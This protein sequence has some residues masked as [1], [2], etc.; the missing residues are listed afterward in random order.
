VGQLS[1]EWREEK[2]TEQF[3]QWELRGRGW[4]VWEYS[5]TP[6]PAYRPFRGHWVPSM[7]ALDDGRTQTLVSSLLDKLSRKI[8][9]PS[10]REDVPFVEE[11]PSPQCLRR[12]S[13]V[14]LQ[15]TLS[16]KLDVTR[17]SFEQL[18]SNLSFC[19]EPIAFELVGTAESIVVQFVAHPQDMQQVRQQLE[20]YFPDVVFT[21]SGDVLL[22][23]WNRATNSSPLIVEFGLVHE[24]MIPLSSRRMDLFV[25]LTAAL[26]SLSE[27]E[28]AVYQVL[29]QPVENPWSQSILRAVTDGFGKSFFENRPDLLTEAKKKI[30]RPLYAAVLRVA[31]KGADD[32]RSFNVARDLVSALCGSVHPDGNDLIPLSNE[33]YPRGVHE[34]DLL[35]RQSQRS[36]M[37]LNSSELI[38]LVH[39]P[40]AAVRSAKLQREQ[41]NSRSPPKIASSSGGLLLGQNTSAG[42][43]I[44]VRL[45]P[46]QR[47]RHVHVIGAS[48]TG[49]S[50]L[51]LSLIAQD[52][53]AGEG[54]AV[55][56]P[57]GD[58]IDSILNMIPANRV[59]DVILFDPSDEE[60]SIG[61][62]I[63]SAHSDLEK[64]LLASDL[65]SV[66]QRLST[67]WGDQ[68]SSVLQN[69]I[70][71]FLESSRGGTLADLRRFLLEASFRKEFLKSVSDSEV[72]YYWEK[73]FPQLSGNRSIGPI[74]TRLETFLSP[75]P[76]RY[77][78]SQRANRLD[79]ANII[80]N[81][82]IF[83]AKLPQGL[84]GRENAYLLGSLLVT[85]F[86]QL[87]MARQA[88]SQS[89]RRDFWLYIDEFHNFI[90]PSMAEILTGARKYRLGLI[91]AHQ[92]LRQLQRDSEVASAV[93]A[94]SY[95]R[96]VFRVG[97][98]DAK[99]LADGFSHFESND[100]LNLGTAE[101]ICRIE[102]SDF[103]FNL[104][105]PHLPLSGISVKGGVRDRVIA[106]SRKH[107]ATPRVEVEKELSK[108]HASSRSNALTTKAIP[109][110][111]IDKSPPQIVDQSKA[112]PEQ[113]LKDA[114]VT[115][116]S[117]LPILPS[118]P[119]R[120]VML[121]KSKEAEP[122]RLGKGGAKHTH[123]Q[124][125][126]KQWAQGMGYR[127]TTEHAIP[128]THE[129]VDVG[130]E[131]PGRRIAC[132]ISMTSNVEQEVAN[133]QKCLAAGFDFV[134]L[135]APEEKRLKRL[136]EGIRTRIDKAHMETVKFLTVDGLFA[137][138]ETLDAQDV[139]PVKTVRGYKVKVTR[140]VVDKMSKADRMQR[141]AKVLGDSLSQP[142]P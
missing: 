135:V 99:P 56:D 84:V 63:L 12:E 121:V 6:E 41:S 100:L 9:P 11:E 16:P 40:S 20:A 77:M 115:A 139:P 30:A 108:L 96:V 42:A 31:V 97:D 46:E 66:F 33:D 118:Q 103:D 45:T 51:L 120:Q 50:T 10:S 101:A 107:Y 82:K 116:K 75:K 36:G 126:I 38:D 69:A 102:R 80:N 142:K 114:V 35:L 22:S 124:Q 2:L 68:M 136:E 1:S 57:H 138:I 52:I 55:L 67:S 104:S 110:T 47:V 25:A 117:V 111:P 130:L 125:L 88:Q 39:L 122:K 91:L 128:G 18:L 137:F 19:A 24:F 85:K 78:V 15:A 123:L 132:E 64:T 141:I 95:T 83:L 70:L 92:E 79:F 134:V 48:G 8:S 49:K 44:D 109:P 4:K 13:L 129:H 43:T 59:D 29:F 27:D 113:P 93:L 127:A 60:Y 7:S 72:I 34:E 37:L 32:N 94:N 87:V 54:L 58:L 62:N 140:T 131:K 105:V 53:T 89:E 71:A 61:F 112:A 106:A 65:V 26:S 119:E 76:I 23:A 21:A 90:T 74:L 3:Y 81:G 17:D 28:A 73:A 5:V 133:I 98:N 86:Q 14:A